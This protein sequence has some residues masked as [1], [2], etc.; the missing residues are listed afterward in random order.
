MQR[1][2]MDNTATVW[3]RS[4]ASAGLPGAAI[5]QAIGA[6][7]TAKLVS[8]PPS[9]LP[10]LVWEYGLSELLPFVPN[11]Y[12]LI[13]AGI[14]WQ[15][16]RGT[17]A[18]IDLGLSWLGYAAE[19]DEA[20][21]GRTYWNLFHLHLDKVRLARA[22]LDRIEGI[23]RLSSPTRSHF[24]RGYHGFDIR[25]LTYGAGSFSEAHYG[26]FSGVRLR[27]GGPLWSFGRA[28][29]FDHALTAFEL[30]EIGVF[31]PEVVEGE[32]V[33]W[34]DF[35]WAD[36]DA[37]W[38]S[39]AA[40]VRALA[41]A[42]GVVTRPAWIA[43]MDA[44]GDTIGLRRAR[45]VHYVTPAFAGPYTIQ[46][47]AFEVSSEVSP[48]LYVEAMTDFG[49]GDGAEVASVGLVLD[50]VPTDPHTPGLFWADPDQ[51]SGGTAPI[52]VQ[53]LAV[54]LGESIRERVKFLLRF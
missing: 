21:W 32:T 11:L 47:G 54:R 40:L 33:G 41:M 19:P 7:A 2:L 36:T 22:D 25:P 24:W 46:G 13:N 30:E 8:P 48:T 14:T 12:S 27:D 49:E 50:A 37:T 1:A 51:L 10:W 23:A 45:A 17:M 42:A 4:A 34:G 16:L 18:A 9:L 29:E 43:F 20:W 35:A 6:V 28:H 5:E 53:P 26:E 52:A 15:R 44:G 38:Q 31:L 3:E 39:D